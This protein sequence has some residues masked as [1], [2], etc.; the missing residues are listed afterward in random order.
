M[1]N[2]DIF[3]REAVRSGL[4]ALIPRQPHSFAYFPGRRQWPS[5]GF[6]WVRTR[7]K[8][9]TMPGAKGKR[10]HS[11]A[12]A[13]QRE[14]AHDQRR[15]RKPGRLSLQRHPLRFDV[16]IFAMVRPTVASDEEA[17]GLATIFDTRSVDP[18][19]ISR[20][21]DGELWT[22]IS[23]EYRGGYGDEVKPARI[24][25]GRAVRE[26]KPE[27]VEHGSSALVN[28]RDHV[29]HEAPRLVAEA[30]RTR[31][32]ALAWLIQSIGGLRMLLIALQASNV[33]SKALKVLFDVDPG[34]LPKVWHLGQALEKLNSENAVESKR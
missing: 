18:A 2:P 21:V 23:T 6:P 10:G 28:R 24:V 33:E 4:A 20:I 9:R 26:F 25:D 34:W 17:A 13:S 22:G 15:G 11:R 32:P 3:E 14:K 29:A 31:G 16:A 7:G 5:P 19:W 30:Y 8:L 27:T 1:M 12:R